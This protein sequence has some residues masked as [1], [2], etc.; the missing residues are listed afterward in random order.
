[1]MMMNSGLRF[2][3]NV[4]DILPVLHCVRI[5]SLFHLLLKECSNIFSDNSFSIVANYIFITSL[6]VSLLITIG[7]K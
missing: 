3:E 4:F 1:M 5:V 2:G 6:F 7:L